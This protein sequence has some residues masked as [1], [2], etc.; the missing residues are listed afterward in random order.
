MMNMYG[1]PFSLFDLGITDPATIDSLSPY[2][3]Y[4]FA[5]GDYP[6][7]RAQ[8]N[9]SA[10]DRDA[11]PPKRRHDGTS[12][13][14]LGMDWSP[15][16]PIWD[17]Q[18]SVWPHDYHSG[19]S[20]CVTI[21]SW[22][23]SSESSNSKSIVLYKVIVGIQSPQG[24]TSTREI[25]R[26]FSD[27]VTLSSDLRKEF[28][29]K[30]LPPAPRKGLLRI[31]DNNLLEERRHLLEDWMTNV[32][33]S[34]IDLS[35]SLSI[36]IFIELEAAVRSYFN[37][38]NNSIPDKGGSSV[39]GAVQSLQ[40]SSVLTTDE[41]SKTLSTM[42]QRLTSTKNLETEEDCVQQSDKGNVQQIVSI[43]RE[44]LT[45][46]L[47]DMDELRRKCLEMEVSLKP[48]QLKNMQNHTLETESDELESLRSSHSELT[49]ELGV[50]KKQKTE[51]EANL[52]EERQS[53][54]HTEATNNKLLLQCMAI[55]TR[56]E[57]CS[58]DFH[59]D[60]ENDL[61]TMDTPSPYDTLAAYDDRMGFLLSEAELLARD[62]ENAN[63][64]NSGIRDD[65]DLRKMITHLL[66]DNARLMKQMNRV[67]RCALCV[68]QKSEIDEEE[69][70]P[71][72]NV[73]HSEE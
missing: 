49:Q 23:L 3:S 57:E 29:K 69:S 48:E 72:K 31:R 68:A 54:K 5:A 40:C 38:S 8:S 59:V 73:L 32:L 9:N 45:K 18:N 10:G 35:R 53:R 51:L 21:P 2:Y 62:V 25:L 1:G 30:N 24:I 47:C 22:T 27:F 13:L 64:G 28:P 43:E 16:P 15:P 39:A 66:T 36:A 63:N 4:P 17:G 19:W 33:S 56:L 26:R 42:R 60:N 58:I 61:I 70:S 7:L 37:D 11:I 12:P 20:Y 71:E 44:K 14:P 52:H 41:Q 65:V 55:R 50:L 6:G 67:I 34:D 46:I